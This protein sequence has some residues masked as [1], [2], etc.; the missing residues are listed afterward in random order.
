[1]GG[2]RRRRRRRKAFCTLTVSER[3]IFVSAIS[4]SE[5]GEY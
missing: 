3:E 5:D 4:D 2:R 1:M